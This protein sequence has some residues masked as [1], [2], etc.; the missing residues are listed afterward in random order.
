M[1]ML[2]VRDPARLLMEEGIAGDPALKRQL[3]GFLHQLRER[4]ATIHGAIHLGLLARLVPTTPLLLVR[5]WVPRH[6]A[7]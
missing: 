1:E 3:G 5:P 4:V 7:L 6:L 2:L